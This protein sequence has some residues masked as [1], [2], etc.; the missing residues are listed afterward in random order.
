MKPYES[1]SAMNLRRGIFVSPSRHM[2]LYFSLFAKRMAKCDQ[3]KTTRRSTPSPYET[4]TPF[5]LLLTL[6]ATSVTCTYI[7]SSMSGGGITTCA[8]A[9]VTKRKPHLKPDT[10]FLNQP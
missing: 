4:N 5:H 7:L 3:C 6:S 2:L 1:S 9:K 10:G 8:S